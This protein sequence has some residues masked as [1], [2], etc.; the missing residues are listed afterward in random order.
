M[1]FD[2]NFPT[3]LVSKATVELSGVPL[4]SFVTWAQQ[5]VSFK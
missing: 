4:A 2:L 5:L 3:I 1:V